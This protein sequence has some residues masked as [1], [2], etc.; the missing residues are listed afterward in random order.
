FNDRGILLPE[1][2]TG[3]FMMGIC[4]SELALLRRAD[5]LIFTLP[6]G[7]DYRT[8]EITMAQS[9][10]NFCMDC[11]EIGAFCF[12][13]S[14][15]WKVVYHTLAAYSTAMVSHGLSMAHLPG[16]FRLE[17]VVVEPDA[18]EPQ[19]P[20]PRPDRPLRILHVPNHQHFKG[21]R[22]LEAAITRLSG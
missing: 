10:F 12:C 7:A 1:E 11:P 20:D 16:S 15:R 6:Y 5:K 19:Y 17:L 3:R 8:R 2:N 4:R 9:R 18:I 22:Y 21:T 13:D 14:E